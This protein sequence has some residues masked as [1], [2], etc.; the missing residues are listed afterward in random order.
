MWAIIPI[1][2]LSKLRYHDVSSSGQSHRAVSVGTEIR[3]QVLE[4]PTCPCTI[5]WEPLYK[6]NKKNIPEP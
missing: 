6:T 4:N 2:Y 3:T 5:S 1:L